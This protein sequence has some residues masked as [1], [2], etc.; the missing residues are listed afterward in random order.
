[1]NSFDHRRPPFRLAKPRRFPEIPGHPPEH[2]LQDVRSR[3]VVL[4]EVIVTWRSS[5][6]R[7]IES[8]SPLDGL[9]DTA[10]ADIRSGPWEPTMLAPLLAAS[11]AAPF[12]VLVSA[13]LIAIASG[14]ASPIAVHAQD[15]G[16]EDE[17][18]WSTPA[19]SQPVATLSG[20]SLR[21]GIGF[22]EGPDSLLLG[23]ELPYAFD[24][25]VSAGP[26][27]Q[28]GIDSENTIVAPSA[29]VTITIADLPGKALDRFK[30]FVSIGLGFAVIGDDDRQNA[31]TGVG[32][33]IPVGFGVE[34]PVSDRL[35]LGSHMTLNF[36]PEET[37]NQEFWFSWQVG[38]IR[39]AF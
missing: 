20:W 3:Q 28:V 39:V 10:S 35:S 26:M 19:R 27:L 9:A 5:S 36:L 23:F 7:I 1:M 22:T 25:W 29:N 14:L 11:F 16:S 12:S 15:W 2:S 30:P 8:P 6:A 18:S 38:T 13:F 37:L 4:Q 21:G 31:N 33:L 24:Q 32:F 34:Y 17:G